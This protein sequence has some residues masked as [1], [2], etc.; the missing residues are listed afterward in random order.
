MKGFTIANLVT[1]M[2]ATLVALYLALVPAG[3]ALAGSVIDVLLPFV[4]VPNTAGAGIVAVF[5]VVFAL[6]SLIFGIVD[7]LVT[8]KRRLPYI[9]IELLLPII[10]IAGCICSLLFYYEVTSFP[11]RLLISRGIGPVLTTAGSF[12]FLCV[13]NLT[14][15]ML[16]ALIKKKEKPE[17]A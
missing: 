11:V 17:V 13:L 1:H 15:T 3:A 9:V 10:G 8:S 2:I 6:L 7:F 16:L 12:L 4:D 5:F 14:F